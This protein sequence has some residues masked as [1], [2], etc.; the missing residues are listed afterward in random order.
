[1][2]INTK[3]EKGM[4]VILALLIVGAFFISGCIG[5][6]KCGEWRAPQPNHGGAI[7]IEPPDEENVTVTKTSL[8]PSGEGL[9]VSNYY[10]C[11]DTITSNQPE[12]IIII[13]SV[14]ACEPEN[15]DKSYSYQVTEPDGNTY[16]G[17]GN[18][19]TLNYDPQKLGIHEVVLNASCNGV[20]C[21]PCTIYVEFVP[22]CGEWAPIV[23][24]FYGY[25][26][27]Y[28][29]Y[30]EGTRIIECGDT[31]KLYD[32]DYA[33]FPP[34]TKFTVNSSCNCVPP[35]GSSPTYSWKLIGPDNTVIDQGAGLST[36]NF[37]INQFMNWLYTGSY[38]VIISAYCD[39]VECDTCVFD[40]NTDIIVGIEDK[41]GREELLTVGSC[42]EFALPGEATDPSQ[43]LLD[44]IST[45]YA[46]RDTK[47]CDE[48]INDRYWAHTFTGLCKE[49]YISKSTR[50][51]LCPCK[52]TCS[53]PYNCNQYN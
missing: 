36:C 21:P 43:T 25:E 5:Q 48:D 41:E 6:P 29:Q 28:Q 49:D 52:L 24:Y 37:Q 7:P 42:D 13:E 26:S 39:G 32:M 20:I 9:P 30:L 16:T 34:E 19:V 38:E 22:Q 27:H 40:F 4:A 3:K 35:G 14:I 18:T 12:E 33:P 50:I 47:D 31:L 11:G 44:W 23:V 15:C 10:F 45:H 46:F 51:H 8:S 17:S 1:M 2:R 53:K